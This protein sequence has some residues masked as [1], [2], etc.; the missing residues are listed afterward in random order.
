MSECVSLF[1]H[2][3]THT[4]VHARMHTHTHTCFDQLDTTTV[5][6]PT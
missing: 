5:P 2:T 4:L 6:L 1:V 3:S